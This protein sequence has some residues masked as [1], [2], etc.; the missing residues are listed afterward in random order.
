MVYNGTS[1]G[2]NTSLWDPHIAIHKVVY[3]L[4]A[5]EKGNFVADRE[6]SLY[7]LP[8]YVSSNYN[9]NWAVGFQYNSIGKGG[10][11]LHPYNAF[12][13]VSFHL[14]SCPYPS[15]SCM[16]PPPPPLVPPTKLPSVSLPSPIFLISTPLG[17]P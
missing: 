17:Q 11:R 2:L 8:T 1:S 6:I 12:A 15:P 5:V 13:A 14:I 4:C 10:I 16:S 7:I 9:H 3:N